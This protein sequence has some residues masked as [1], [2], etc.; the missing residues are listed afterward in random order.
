MRKW[1]YKIVKFQAGEG[2]AQ[3]ICNELG[4]QGW[5]HYAITEYSFDEFKVRKHFFFLWFKRSSEPME[6]L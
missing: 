4:E 1:A 5:E 3:E 6:R 2:D